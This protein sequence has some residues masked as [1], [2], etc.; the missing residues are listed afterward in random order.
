MAQAPFCPPTKQGKKGPKPILGGLI[1]LLEKEPTSL[2][3]VITKK[4]GLTI[5]P[6]DWISGEMD[7]KRSMILVFF[8]H[9]HYCA[10]GRLI[11]E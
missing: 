4:R 9:D 5:D 11:K 8:S 6:L 10:H 2:S 7:K 3:M 1:L